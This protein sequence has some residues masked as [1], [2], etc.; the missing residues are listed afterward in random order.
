MQQSKF[1]LWPRHVELAS[2][3]RL[4]GKLDALIR[5]ILPKASD[6]EVVRI[7]S[8]RVRTDDYMALLAQME[9]VQ[10]L[11]AKED[12]KDFQQEQENVVKELQC[13][14]QVGADWQ[15]MKKAV[16]AKHKGVKTKFTKNDFGRKYPDKW[17]TGLLTRDELMELV[18]P[19]GKIYE[20]SVNGRYQVVLKGVTR[21]RNWITYG[22][23]LAGRLAIKEAWS[24]F[25]FDEC[26]PT[27]ACPI[28]GVMAMVPAKE[29]A[30]VASGSGAASSS[31]GR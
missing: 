21:S 19:G 3:S 12:M 28:E 10:D 5:N 20:D 24:L 30:P 13:T 25:L 8:Q 11:V 18:P 15:T 23:D 6:V 26:L 2:G 29:A 16:M 17:P 22:K 7:L 1:S 4:I 27:S 31:G 14:N 9:D